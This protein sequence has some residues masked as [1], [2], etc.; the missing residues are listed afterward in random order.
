MP[1]IQGYVYITELPV[2]FDDDDTDPVMTPVNGH[3]TH[4]LT[5]LKFKL[6]LISRRS[7][8]RAGNCFNISF[9]IIAVF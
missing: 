1:I 6:C 9:V 3:Q 7:R 4:E 8:Y 2:T 5:E